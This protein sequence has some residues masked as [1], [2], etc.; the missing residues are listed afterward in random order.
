MCRNQGIRLV[1]VLTPTTYTPDCR[2]KFNQIIPLL[3]EA[4]IEYLDLFPAV[5]D[6]LHTLN[7]RSLWANPANAHPGDRLTTLY[8]RETYKYIQGHHLL[9][10]K[11]GT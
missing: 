3:Q 1:V 10:E 4:G 7:T 2:Q 5:H 11:Q 6:Q 8:A 9:H